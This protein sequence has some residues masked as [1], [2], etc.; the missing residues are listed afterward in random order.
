LKKAVYIFFL[1]QVVFGFSV[2][3]QIS[4]P[5]SGTSSFTASRNAFYSASIDSLAKDTSKTRK[6][7]SWN[8]PG[9]VA[10]Q[11][12][13]VPGLGQISNGKLHIIKVPVIYAGFAVCGYFINYN[14]KEYQNF[15][16]AY[17]ARI[18]G[19]T[20][21]YQDYKNFSTERLLFYRES[22]RQ[23]RD[24]TIIITVGIYAANILDAYVF[25]HLKD[26]DVSE[27]LALHVKPVTFSNIAGRNHITSGIQLKFK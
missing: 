9:M 10:L 8:S 1:L 14:N 18:N 7:I 13:L 21:S 26:F 25:A 27:N 17:T 15:R 3:A 20:T 22:F 24:L 16:K 6:K 19:D 11:S 2:K 4:N 23:D 5:V 12:A